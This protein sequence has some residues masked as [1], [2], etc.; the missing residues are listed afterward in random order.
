MTRAYIG[1]GSNLMPE[2]NVPAALRLL[3][4][5][6]RLVGISAFYAS[7]AEGR[8]EQPD[9]A[10]G[11]VAIETDRTPEA[12]KSEVLRPIEARLGRRRTADR[13]AARPIDLD[14]LLF[15]TLSRSGPELRLPSPDIERRAFVAVPLAELAPDLVVGETGVRLRDLAAGFSLTGLRPLPAL[16]AR[17]KRDAGFEPARSLNPYAEG[18]SRGDR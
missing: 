16:T 11:V 7:P 1:V 18:R 4:G 14:L 8:P 3:A 15:G 17:L 6:V 5:Q 2:A 10:N 9:Y 12:L 13:F